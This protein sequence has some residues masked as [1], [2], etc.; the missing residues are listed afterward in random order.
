MRRKEIPSGKGE[1]GNQNHNRHKDGRD[2]VRQFL[3]RRLA[4]LRVFHQFDD[5][6]QRGLLADFGRLELQHA[7]FV[8]GRADD[9]VAGLLLEG[10]RLPRQH[11]LVHRAPALDDDPVHGNLLAGFN[12]DHVADAHIVHG[13]LNFKSRANDDG[14]FGAQSH[15][16][17]DRLGGASLGAGFEIFAEPDQRDDHRR[18]LVIDVAFEP[19]KCDGQGIQERHR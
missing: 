18:R 17:L 5:L 9:R 15:Q 3:D 6:R 11:G 19:A 13:H 8:Q 14:R 12:E 4:P 2:L 1:Q 16:F 7:Q 10:Q